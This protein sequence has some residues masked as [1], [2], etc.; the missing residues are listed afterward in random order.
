[1]TPFGEYVVGSTVAVTVFYTAVSALFWGVTGRAKWP[2]V[3][4]ARRLEAARERRLP[5]HEPIP[6]VLL[7]LELRRLGAEMQRIDAS[8]LPAK[9]MRLRA[10]TAAYDYVLLECCRSLEV[11]IPDKSDP[12]NT[13][14][15]NDQRSTAE[16]SL[17]SAGFTW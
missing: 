9:A 5:P 10:T 7:G 15:T 3:T 12:V 1:M 2:F 14:L 4:L 8:D 13:P 6:P 16:L 11:P 17:L